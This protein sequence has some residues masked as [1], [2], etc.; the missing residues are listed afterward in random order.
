MS[1]SLKLL[2]LAILVTMLSVT[3]WAATQESILKIPPAV[4]GDPWFIAT[5][6]DAYFAFL[7]IFLFVCY[8]EKSFLRKAI[9]GIAFAALG[10]IAISVYMLIALRKLK[11]G[12]G[13]DEFF[14]RKN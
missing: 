3:S 14:S 11:P 4:T 1:K 12:S 2:F 5:L 6:F 8:R 7:V 10:N 13:I 9:W